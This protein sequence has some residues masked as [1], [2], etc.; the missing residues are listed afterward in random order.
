MRSSDPNAASSIAVPIH[1]DPQSNGLAE[2]LSHLSGVLL[3]NQAPG[4]IEA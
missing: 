1:F 4:L 3:A 2:R